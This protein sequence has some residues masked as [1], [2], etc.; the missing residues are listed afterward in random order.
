VSFSRLELDVDFE[1]GR[2]CQSEKVAL[3]DWY[4]RKLIRQAYF[5]QSE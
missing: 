1:I 4:E 5:W 2:R 3:G